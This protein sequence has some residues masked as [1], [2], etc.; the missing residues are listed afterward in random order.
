MAESATA[1]A[2]RRRLT[3]GE[4]ERRMLDAGERIF[5]ARGFNAV[6]M[7]EVAEASGITKALLYQYF[8]SKE[9]LYESCVERARERLFDAVREAGSTGP[10]ERRLRAAVEAYFDHVD[11]NRGAWWILYGDASPAA[12]NRMRS[13]NAEVVGALLRDGAP[14]LAKADVELMGHLIVGSGEQIGR[15]WIEHPEMPRER[16]V[17]RYLAAIAGALGGLA[18]T[19]AP[20]AAAG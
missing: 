4:R 19:G 18:G 11:A 5:G 6:S 16:A 15:W 9:G 20:A 3:R 1:T 12:V 13:R 10:P 7:D 2:P 17:E 8:G 14:A